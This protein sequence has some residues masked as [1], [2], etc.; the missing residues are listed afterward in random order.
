MSAL[1]VE[2]TGDIL[3]TLEAEAMRLRAE[4]ERVEKQHK[5]AMLKAE[6]ARSRAE[7]GQTGCNSR[8]TVET[9]GCAGTVIPDTTTLRYIFCPCI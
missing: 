8:V 7:K 5:V 4:N 9:G 6:I 3:E 2:D 1:S